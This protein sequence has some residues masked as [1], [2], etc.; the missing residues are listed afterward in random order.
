MTPEQIKESTGPL[1]DGLKAS[2]T[3]EGWGK[4]HREAIGISHDM[5]VMINFIAEQHIRFKAGTISRKEFDL[6]LDYGD[7]AI[8]VI[9]E[10]FISDIGI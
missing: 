10:Q 3:A 8:G 5:L 7:D 2:F 1:I 9:K 6:A 4:A